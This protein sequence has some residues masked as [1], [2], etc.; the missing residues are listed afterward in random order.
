MKR[1]SEIKGKGREEGRGTRGG[2][3][4]GHG[5]REA[6]GKLRNS[7][8]LHSTSQNKWNFRHEGLQC[9]SDAISLVLTYF[10]AP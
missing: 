5:K 8:L 9:S 10:K 4:Q 3:G 2:G 1:A 6:D 7:N